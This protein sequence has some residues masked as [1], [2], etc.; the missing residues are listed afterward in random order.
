MSMGNKPI[1]II[2]PLPPVT[3]KNSQRIIYAGGRPRLLPSEKY[4]EWEH[5]AGYFLRGS[6][7][8]KISEPVNVCCKFYMPTR[9]R[10]D[11]NNLL[12]AVTDMLVHYGVVEDDNSRIVAGHDGSRVFYD[13]EHPRTEIA[14]WRI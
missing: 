4:Q 9:R 13:K 14:I 10:V 3:K 7:W 1:R 8:K 2:I 12:E 11:L 6:A 5:E